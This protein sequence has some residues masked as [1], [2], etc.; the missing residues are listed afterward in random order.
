MSKIKLAIVDDHKGLRESIIKLIE[1]D[2][3]LEVV[4]EAENGSQL[5]GQL[6]TVTPDIILMDI[7]M[8]VMDGF[9]A[10]KKVNELYPDI[11]IIV[12]TLYD[13]EANIIE[14]Y[15]L[16]VQS[17]IGK[18]D[19]YNELFMA[20]KTVSNGG[21]YT[22]TM[23]KEIIQAKLNEYTLNNNS[24]DISALSQLTATE[25]IVLWYVS[26]FKTVKEIAELLS[27]SPNTIN[28]H[29]ANIRHKLT[30]RGKNSLLQYALSIKERLIF[31]EG[32]VNFKK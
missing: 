22:T 5:L 21:C 6:K 31:V 25:L 8:D 10:T 1:T 12:L 11:K 4:L 7:Q 28:N 3:D 26:Q 18:E 20:I 9:E 27:T 30:L 16:G 29:E 32:V 17:L 24:K 2:T 15:R 23:C 19:H 13:N 14:M